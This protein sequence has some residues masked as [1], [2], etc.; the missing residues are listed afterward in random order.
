MGSNT[1]SL[2]AGT[3]ILTSDLLLITYPNTKNFC[4]MY[5][6]YYCFD[7]KIP[8]KNWKK[9]HMETFRW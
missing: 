9:L 8:A 7:H 3:T 1:N 6:V 5:E 4:R 2:H